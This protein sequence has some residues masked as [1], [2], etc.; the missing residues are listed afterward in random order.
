[1]IKKSVKMM[2]ILFASSMLLTSCYSYTSVV[3]EGAQGNNETT[4]WNH[5]VVY[6]LAPVGVSDSKEMAGDAENYT[7]HT[8]QSFVNGLV[9][10]LTFGLYSPTTTTVTK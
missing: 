6:G 10:A 1:M 8:R 4:K 3:G 2:T 7:V 9:S 5:Y